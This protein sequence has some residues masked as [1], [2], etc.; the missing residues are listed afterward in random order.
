MVRSERTLQRSICLSVGP[1]CP[2]SFVPVTNTG[3]LRSERAGASAPV[4]MPDAF[5][6]AVLI[7]ALVGA[8]SSR[9][10]TRTSPDPFS[11][12][13]YLRWPS[14][15]CEERTDL[16]ILHGLH[17]LTFCVRRAPNLSVTLHPC[18]EDGPGIHRVS[19]ILRR[20]SPA[21]GRCLRSRALRR[22]GA[23]NLHSV[24]ALP[25]NWSRWQ[26]LNLRPLVPKTSALPTELHQETGCRGRTCTCDLL[27]MNQMR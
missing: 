2:A 8:L 7:I 27:G 26:D 16:P 23:Y 24:E 12:C 14:A 10:A 19:H 6:A 1:Y 4:L 22:S 18:G 3:S 25:R 20:L 13:G 21:H 9:L 17:R 15:T 11:N 5:S